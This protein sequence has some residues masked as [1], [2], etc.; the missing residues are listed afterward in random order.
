MK[1]IKNKTIIS[2]WLVSFAILMFLYYLIPSIIEQNIQTLIVD[3]SKRMVQQIKLTRTYYL[4][5]IMGK[6][7]EQ[8]SDFH[9]VAL[10]EKDAHALPLPSTVIHDLSE[11]Y[12]KQLG[13]GF[14]T[15]SNFP[16]KNRSS[17]VLSIH[18]KEVLDDINFNSSGLHIDKI[19]IE[20]KPVLKVAVADYMKESCVECH[21]NHPNKTWK[22]SKWKV[23]DIRGVIEI[24]TPITKEMSNIENT[25][26]M[27]L[28]SIAILFALLILYYSFLFLKREDELLIV[29]KIL[30]ERVKAEVE[31]NKEKEQIL[32]QKSKLS[33]MGEMLN[34]IAH[35]WRQPLNELSSLLMNID[36]RYHQNSL[37]KKF[38]EAKIQKSEVLV[39]YLSHTIDDFKD[40]F[41]VNKE[42][43]NFN[44]EKLINSTLN[45]SN[46]KTHKN[47]AVELTV[48]KE[49]NYYGLETELSQ[50]L[51]N[52]ISNAKDAILNNNIE[53]GY[54][55]I[56]VLKNKDAIEISIEDNAGGISQENLEKVF[57]LY[58]TTKKNG[59]GI[60]LY[61]SKLIIEKHFLGEIQL[62]SLKGKTKFEICLNGNDEL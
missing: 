55:L 3:S 56:S 42:K 37:D 30:D 44:L 43:K 1:I 53:Q 23:G 49:V 28:I 2:L 36:T 54:I 29:N 51:L 21:N 32:I 6:I 47:I 5:N 14:R 24:S 60:G 11:L 4:D 62:S 31:K 59:S 38:M 40:F 17:R 10:H 58:Y 16:F 8:N 7:Q 46:I 61:M 25:K 18:D 15:Y 13:T 20:G 34:N 57:E 50:V 26:N 33:S 19:S 39:E 27:I 41:N 35:Q 52:I 45:I 9:F 48:D 12:T 22:N